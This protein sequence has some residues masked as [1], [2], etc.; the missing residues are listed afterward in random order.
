MHNHSQVYFSIL[1]QQQQS[2]LGGRDNI[3]KWSSSS[4]SW[5][6]AAGLGLGAQVVTF[7]CS[8]SCFPEK[9]VIKAD[10]QLIR[11]PEYIHLLIRACAL[12]NS[13]AACAHAVVVVVAAV[14]VVVVVAVVVVGL[15]AAVRNF[16]FNNV[17]T[18]SSRFLLIPLFVSLEQ[19]NVTIFPLFHS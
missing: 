12:H 13:V 19:K 6:S 1:P 5:A 17:V 8:K 10:V 9:S 16:F 15:L 3:K 11:R 2:G 4:S 7:Y 14:V 18:L